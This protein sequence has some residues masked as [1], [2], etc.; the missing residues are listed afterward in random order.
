MAANSTSLH[1]AWFQQ[2]VGFAVQID[3]DKPEYKMNK[4]DL[5]FQI[6][7]DGSATCKIISNNKTTEQVSN[8]WVVQYPIIK[9]NK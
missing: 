9:I 7:R 1:G 2:I 3:T 6:A 4:F 5:K 8:F